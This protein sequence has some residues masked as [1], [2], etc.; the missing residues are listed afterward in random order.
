MKIAI[1][2]ICTGKYNIFWKDF[3]TSCEKNFIPNSEKHY[4]VFT[5]SENID[6]EKEKNNISKIYQKNL[7]WPDNTLKRYEM[8]LKI[9]GDLSKFQYTFFFNAN[10]LFI[11]EISDKDFLPI[12][13]KK[14]VGCIH[15][16]FYQTK[17]E[18][19]PFEKNNNSL[20]FLEEREKRY[21][22]QGAINGGETEY[23]L[24]TIEVLKKNIDSDLNN[25]IIAIW[26]D[27][28]HWNSFLNKNLD[29]VKTIPQE[30]LYPEGK[31]LSV[32]PKILMLGKN[33]YFGGLGKIRGTK[34]RI[35]KE[36][37]KKIIDKI[38][39]KI[40]YI[41]FTIFDNTFLSK[42]TI[43]WQKRVICENSQKISVAISSYHRENLIHKSLFNILNNDRIDEIVILDDGSSEESFGKTKK[44]IKSINNKKIKLYRREKNL[45]VLPTKIEAVSLCKNDWVILLDSDNT[46]CKSYIDGIYKNN[47]SDNTI[48]SPA[49]AYPLLDFRKISGKQI[50]FKTLKSLLIKNTLITERFLNDGNFFFN[51]NRFL[52][53]VSKYKFI[54]AQASDIIFI[55]YL[56]L[57]NDNNI[58]IMPNTKYLHR[59]HIKSIWKELQ[60][61]SSKIFEYLRYNILLENKKKKEEI[62]RDLGKNLVVESKIEQIL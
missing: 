40:I 36:F 12:D 18:K 53:L 14:L 29:I 34:E 28:S 22:Y 38:K 46:I 58:Y 61:S 4:F 17:K 57:I 50:D 42:T 43:K 2:Y 20:A 7:G 47:W 23:F 30:Y 15:P 27:E 48:Y 32:S 9:K 59:V 45:G 33:R 44:I 52:K 19:W 5:D 1:L 56:W 60:Q 6:F 11:E 13:N 35:S 21:Y 26:H 62:E 37:I 49:F 39:T 54:Q 51:K 25:N 16:G 24:N 31:S 10:I 3:Y 8:F 55:N 41:L